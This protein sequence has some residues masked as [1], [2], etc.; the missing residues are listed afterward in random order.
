MACK[1]RCWL[2]ADIIYPDSRKRSQ[3]WWILPKWLYS[4]PDSC[5]GGVIVRGDLRVASDSTAANH[6]CTVEETRDNGFPPRP[7]RGP[8][9]GNHCPLQSPA[10]SSPDSFRSCSEKMI[11]Q[12]QRET[13]STT[14]RS[15]TSGKTGAG[16]RM[17]GTECQIQDHSPLLFLKRIPY[18][19]VKPCSPSKADGNAREKTASVPAAGI[20]FVR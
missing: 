1:C 17:H 3:A 8:G 18:V 10:G 7:R 14:R 11:A 20:T 16:C 15:L 2:D 5:M 6:S 19:Y 4:L 13:F 9:F 12:G